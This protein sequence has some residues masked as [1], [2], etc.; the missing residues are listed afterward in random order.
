MTELAAPTPI[1]LGVPQT[2]QWL[3]LWRRARHS[4]GILVGAG[5]LIVLAIV[6]LSAPVL[7]SYDPVLMTPKD[8]LKPPGPANI[9]GTDQ[10]GRDML[11]RTLYEGQMSVQVGDVSSPL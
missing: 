2:R 8:R 11:T 9:F 1:K 10:F 6:T 7:T 5:L 3:R 4:T